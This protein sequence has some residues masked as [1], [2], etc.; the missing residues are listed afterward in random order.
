MNQADSQAK[1]TAAESKNKA[2]SEIK[3]KMRRLEGKI[4]NLQEENA[5]ML[6]K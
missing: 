3:Q 5:A 1:R 6:D 4:K 2:S